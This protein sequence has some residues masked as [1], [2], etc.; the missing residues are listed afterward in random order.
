MKKSNSSKTKEFVVQPERTHF[1]NMLVKNPNY[2]GN[3]PGSKLKAN[4]AMSGNITYEEIHCVGYNP[5]SGDLEAIFSVKKPTGYSGDL[6]SAGSIEYVRFYLDFHDGAGFIDQGVV[7]VN[8]HDIPDETDCK[9]KSILP[10]MYAAKLEKKTF[11]L[12]TCK[13][14]L[15]PTLRA[16]L[17]WN[18]EPPADSPN[19]IPVWG[20]VMECDVQY[21]TI[22]FIKPIEF[23][24][25][26]SKYLTLAADLPHLTSKDLSKFSGFDLSKMKPEKKP[27]QLADYVKASQRLKVPESRFA[28][29][30]VHQMIQDPTSEMTLMN[31]ATLG[32]LKI[33]VNK[34]VDEFS[35][36]LPLDK[37]KANVGYEELECL[38]LDYNYENL[39]ATINIKKKYGY[40]GDLCEDGSKEYVAFWIDWDDSCTWE[41]LDTVELNVHDIEMKDDCLCYSVSLPLDTKYHKKICSNP[42]I[43]RIRGVLSWNVPPSTTDPNKLEY[44]GNRLD[45]HIQ[46]KPGIELVPGEVKPIF[47]IIGG[48]DADN[49]NDITGLTKSGSWFS[50]NGLPVPT[51]APFAGTIVING[52]YFSGEKYRIKITNLNDNSFYYLNN[53]FDVDGEGPIP[54]TQ[55]ATNDYYSYLPQE[56]NTLNILAQFK[57]GTNDLLEVELDIQGVP[58]TYSK[59][60]QM[61]NTIT[62]VKVE[63]DDGGDCTHYKKGDTIT[64]HYHVNDDHL[65]EWFFGSTWGGSAS[66]NSNTPPLTGT[67]FSIVTTPGA[68]P[69]GSVWI[70]ARD[71]T[72][73]DSS[74]LRS[75]K[76]DTYIICLQES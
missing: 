53:D 25:E 62:D 26:L 32:D 66:G 46:I 27:L 12:T 74:H 52:P 16:I 31:K 60:I 11:K 13:K 20:N 17:S 67:A 37:S 4:Y 36:I 30:T 22:W 21:K 69:C 24:I 68:Y 8:V 23:P 5:D 58:G 19:W 40:G 43:V 10:L 41:Y 71:K 47:Y 9:G 50:Y 18:Y 49:V 72:I 2:F 33:N 70:K 29:K 39:V 59:V 55:K 28:F 56:K 38:G 15:L 76:W 45:A 61:D 44:Y 51:A 34:L 42:N 48:I 64:G 6:C 3:I 54:T 75:Y 35:I 73:V 63:V 14:P 7:G 65:Y 57:P 1:Q